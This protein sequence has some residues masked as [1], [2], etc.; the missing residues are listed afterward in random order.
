MNA[1]SHETKIRQL[2]ADVL[3]S[4]LRPDGPRD[5]H[6]CS[7]LE[8]L[9]E[10]LMRRKPEGEWFGTWMPYC[11]KWLD[12]PGHV[13]LPLNRRYA[14]LGSTDTTG[15]TVHYDQHADL[16]VTFRADPRM[17]KGAS[18]WRDGGGNQLWLYG[19]DPKSRRRYFERLAN[20]LAAAEPMVI[21][22]GRWGAAA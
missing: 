13:W 1:S 16:A 10:E 4:L 5:A 15:K 2:V 11:F 14:L 17:I 8:R 9:R 3:A 12:R 19:D 22:C 6:G 20:V 18:W 7:F 21:P